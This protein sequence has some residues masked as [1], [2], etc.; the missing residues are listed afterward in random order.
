MVAWL[1]NYSN[2]GDSSVT[3][4][5]IAGHLVVYQARHVV[6]SFAT[7]QIFWSWQFVNRDR[8]VAFCTGPTHS[9]ASGCELHRIISG[10]LLA[11]WSTHGPGD[12]PVWV[13]GLSF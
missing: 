8:D 2:P 9:G 1:A 5:P 13:K 3:A 7:D 12:P 10:R 4:G 6:R 11:R